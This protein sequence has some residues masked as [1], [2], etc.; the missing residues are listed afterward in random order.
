MQKKENGEEASLA[1]TRNGATSLKVLIRKVNMLTNSTF[2]TKAT[3]LTKN[4]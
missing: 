2:A 4:R 3:R 1:D